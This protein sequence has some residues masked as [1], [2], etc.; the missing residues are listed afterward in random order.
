MKLIQCQACLKENSDLAPSCVH[1]GKQI[2]KNLSP[3]DE[4]RINDI[5]LGIEEDKIKNE[6]EEFLCCPKCYGNNLTPMKRG[7]SFG[8]AVAGVFTIGLYGIAAG[9]IGSENIKLFCNGCGNKFNS[10]N[11][12]SLTKSQQKY[13]KKTI[14]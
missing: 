2:K 14:L 5:L 13:F 3:E 11:S 12:I 4:Q 1:C 7:F 10:V 6:M 9:S 8:R